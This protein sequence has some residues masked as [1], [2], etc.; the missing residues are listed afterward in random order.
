MQGEPKDPIS[1]STR[2]FAHA[3]HGQPAEAGAGRAHESN[4]KH[5]PLTFCMQYM[6]NLRKRVQGE[7]ES[8]TIS[9]V[10]TDIE[11]YS[12]LMKQSPELMT[13]ALILHNAAIRKAR[14]TTYG[15]TVEQVCTWGY[16]IAEGEGA[17]R[18][19]HNRVIQKER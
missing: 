18:K 17:W 9:I 14:W 12:T 15:Y 8:G 4:L 19:L 16:S 3:A 2:P 1:I 5:P 13:K 11:G 7:P 10:N 6:V